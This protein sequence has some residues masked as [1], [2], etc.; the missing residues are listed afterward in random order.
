MGGTADVDVVIVDGD[1]DTPGIQDAY[2]REKP[3]ESIDITELVQAYVDWGPYQFGDY[4]TVV[5]EQAATCD[6]I[7]EGELQLY[8][9]WMDLHK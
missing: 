8:V 2:I 5:L 4:F 7:P 9:E 3:Y 1:L 6:P